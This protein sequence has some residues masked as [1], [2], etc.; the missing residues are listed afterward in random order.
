MA[1]V[2]K[3]ELPDFEEYVPHLNLEA[4]EHA[5]LSPNREDAPAPNYSLAD[6][7][8]IK[9]LIWAAGEKWL[10]RD[11]VELED[12]EVEK[13]SEL[14]VNLPQHPPEKVHGFI[15]LQGTLNGVFKPYIEYKGGR[16]AADWKTR[17]GELD[18]NWRTKL[19]DSHQYKIYSAMVGAQVFNYRGI[20]RR[21]VDGVHPT[22]DIIIALPPT[23]AE[24]VQNHL[25]GQFL[26]LNS[27]I[28]NKVEVFPQY[29][30]DACYKFQRQC[31]FKDDCDTYSMPRYP[32]VPGKIMSYTAFSWFSRCPEMYRRMINAPGSDETE[33]ANIGSGTHSGLAN[34]W[35]QAKEI[36][37]C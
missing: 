34:L 24:E 11:M 23:N 35:E 7:K 36:K 5:I 32:L 21:V 25:S 12:I 14:V 1:K 30:P 6:L 27:L 31:A 26:M 20:S 10:P 22:K 28:D 9:S 4:I 17:D 8:E 19:I 29:M 3:I 33:E 16:W 15:D 2:P 18:Q 13:E 37:L